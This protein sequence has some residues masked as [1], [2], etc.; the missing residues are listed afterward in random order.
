MHY[1]QVCQNIEPTAKPAAI[2]ILVAVGILFDPP[3][4]ACSTLA[5]VNAES[6]LK[7][8]LHGGNYSAHNNV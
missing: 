4:F 5:P 6:L 8:T 1:W 7:D 2:A 3:R